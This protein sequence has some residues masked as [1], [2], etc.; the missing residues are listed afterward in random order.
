M[1]AWPVRIAALIVFGVSFALP[2]IHMP[3]SGSGPQFFPGVMCAFLAS[4]VAPG[5]VLSSPGKA[6]LQSFLVVIG[7]LVNYFFL[8]IL[9]LSFWRRLV[10]TRMVIGTLMLPCF[11]AT[12]MF[13]AASKTTPLV[14]HYLWVASAILLM[15]PDMAALLFRSSP[16]AA[17]HEDTAAPTPSGRGSGA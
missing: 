2:A 12:W 14:G 5:E 13:F 10:R 8:A 16:I 17:K 3:G 9:V 7:G 1:K 4:V 15:V 6:D 11:V